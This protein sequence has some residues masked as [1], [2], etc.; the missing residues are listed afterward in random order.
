V[1]AASPA[2]S[3]LPA[4]SVALHPDTAP[5]AVHALSVGEA[6]VL[7]VAEHGRSDGVPAV[8]LHGGPGSGTSPLLRRVFDPQRYRIVC[9]DQR[10]AGLSR[11]RGAVRH[12]DTARLLVDLRR[13]R[14]ALGIDRW[15]VV[16]GSWGATLALL[17]AED[18]PQAVSGLLLRASFLARAQEIAAFLAPLGSPTAL[19]Q[20]FASGPLATRRA[21]ARAWWAHEQALVD[22]LTP[23]APLDDEALAR[24][25]DR[26]RVQ[27]H[28]LAHGCWLGDRPLVDRCAGLPAVPTLLLHGRGDRVCPP[29]GAQALQHALP[30]AALRWIDGAGHDPAHPAMV[31]ATVQALDR[32]AASGRFEDVAP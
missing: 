4:P 10:G 16:G 13:V 22:G 24:Q 23:P 15:L 14:A 2:L 20:A 26:Y 5:F 30:H 18:A 32:F 8:L 7:H 11:P 9:I 19:A 21:M 3:D 1:S 31:A 28:F 29:E 25:L 17:H 27:S 12:N 6:H